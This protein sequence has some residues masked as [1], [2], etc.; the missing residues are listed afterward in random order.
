M[1]EFEPMDMASKD[2]V[3]QRIEQ[4]K[5]LFPEIV[6]ERGLGE[7][8]RERVTGAASISTSCA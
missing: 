7:R 6:T 5:Q 8:E 2:L 1:T 4:L 3:G